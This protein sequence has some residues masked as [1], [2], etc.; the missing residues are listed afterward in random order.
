[1][2]NF[3]AF[4]LKV[5]RGFVLLFLFVAFLF[6]FGFD[7][8]RTFQRDDVMAKISTDHV[9]SLQSPGVTVC[10]DQV[11]FALKQL[12]LDFLVL[13]KASK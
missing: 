11:R 8:G 1:M 3:Q 5:A 6:M 12:N 4:S 7:A 13:G 10:L 9:E 2:G